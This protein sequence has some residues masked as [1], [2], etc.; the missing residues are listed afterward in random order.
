M[1]LSPFLVWQKATP[2]GKKTDL[3]K[4]KIVLHVSNFPEE[5]KQQQKNTNL[6]SVD[7]GQGIKIFIHAYLS[8][9]EKCLASSHFL[10][11][12]QQCVP[13]ISN[14]FQL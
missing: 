11:E 4:K 13:S 9:W 6:A 7:S 2:G 8:N 12:G 1:G 10:V 5:K 14:S 3:K